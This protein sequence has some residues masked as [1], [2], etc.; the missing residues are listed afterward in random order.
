MG[1][2]L[3]V[4]HVLSV[5]GQHKLDLYVGFFVVV[6]FSF[7]EGGRLWGWG[8]ALRTEKWVWPGCLVWNSWIINK[9]I[10]LEISH[11]WI[12]TCSIS[13]LHKIHYTCSNTHT[14]TCI[15]IYIHIHIDSHTYIIYIL[16]IYTYA[17]TTQSTINKHTLQHMHTCPTQKYIFRMRSLS[18][19]CEF[20]LNVFM[21]QNSFGLFTFYRPNE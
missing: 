19:D 14:H 5:Y 10:M 15:H 9:N 3:G 6:S 7:G 2:L 1:W 8:G 11:K 13:L 4:Y 16:Y 17:H 20:G 18:E 12:Q 21:G